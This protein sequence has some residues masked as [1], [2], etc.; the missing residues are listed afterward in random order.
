[1]C[2]EQWKDTRTLV[3]ACALTGAAAFFAGI[4]DAVLVANGPMWC[5]YYALRYLEKQ[6]PAIGSQFFCTQADNHAVVY[7]T[8]DCLLETLQTIRNQTCPSVILV[9]NSCS[10]SLIGDDIAGI[11]RQAD[12][13]CPVVSIDSGGLIGGFGAGY[14]AAAQAYFEQMD[15]S[16]ERCVQHGT[17]NL[18]GC[19]VG[20]YN[21]SNDLAELKRMLSLAGYQVL[22]C[23]GAG[24]STREIS[25]MTNAALNIVVHAELGLDLA[26][27]LHNKYGMP[28]VSLP[29]PYGLQGSLAWLANIEQHLPLLRFNRSRVEQEIGLLE[30]KIQKATL[31][32]QRI[33]G[34]LWFEKTLIAAP[35]S[36][37]V[38]MAEAVRTEWLDTRW[39]TVMAYDSRLDY[40]VPDCIDTFIE[41]SDDSQLIEQQ[42]ATLQGGLL[43]ASSNEKA[44][45]QQQAVKDVVCQNVALPVY[46]EVQLS[47]Q[48]FIGLRGAC[49]MTERL[50]NQ[51]IA[52]SQRRS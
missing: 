28:Y 12:M 43:L 20:Y 49:H 6:C 38:A 40:S 16:Q 25:A 48:P 17:V 5:Y 19:T 32:M 18:L 42:L 41:N 33:W 7:G 44:M 9:E 3:D 39:L 37:A 47:D 36:M 46:D 22:A 34:D 15:L 35:A 1:M 24:S 52:Q 13:P 45:L 11:A 30:Q 23:P 27:S 14:R 50:W 21:G 4:P 10:V 31:E 26:K 8:E 2:K 29:L 51:F